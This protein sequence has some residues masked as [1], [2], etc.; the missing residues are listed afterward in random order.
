MRVSVEAQI[1]MRMKNLG[2]G[3]P[4][5]RKSL[6]ERP[7]HPAPLTATS[8]HPQ[9]AFANLERKTPETGEIA[10]YGVTVEVAL[11]HTPRD[12]GSSPSSTGPLT[13]SCRALVGPP[14]SRAWRFHACRGSLTS[15]V[16]WML[17]ISHP[18]V[19][20]SRRIDSVGILIS[21]YFAARYP[22]CIC[23]CHRFLPSLTTDHA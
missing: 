5:S 15:Q 9:P 16:Q 23:P 2:F 7:R 21:R 8:N 20:P 12:C 18:P 17:A 13:A 14:G 3:E 11:N 6:H 10:G 22:P 1:G 4:L 19:L